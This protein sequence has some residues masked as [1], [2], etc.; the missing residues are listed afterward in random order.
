MKDVNAKDLGASLKNFLQTLDQKKDLWLWVLKYI[1]LLTIFLFFYLPVQG[2]LASHLSE[3]SSLKK[4]ITDL[5]SIMA[6]ML[7]P[8][9]IE[10]VRERVD[11]FEAKLADETKATKILDQISEFAEKNH[12]KL[13]Q[14]YSDSPVSVKNELGKELE[15]NGKKLYLLPVSFRVEADYKSFA[16]FLKTLNDEAAW[17]YTVESFQMQK[18]SDDSESLQCDVTLS[19]VAQ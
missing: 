10:V 1:G 3:T 15:V 17:T 4:Q 14:I 9:E 16:T 18:P 12:L 13:I 6:N 2:R 19:F 8:A 5:K 11:R 7:T